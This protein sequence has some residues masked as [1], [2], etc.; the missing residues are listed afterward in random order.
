MLDCNFNTFIMALPDK[1]KDFSQE[2]VITFSLPIKPHEC[3]NCH[4]ETS[5]VHDYRR[6]KIKTSLTNLCN[7]IFI[8]RRRRYCCPHCK[9]VF[10]EQQTFI[11]KYQQIPYSDVQDI[12]KAHEEI[13]PTTK[14]ARRFCVSPTTVRRI[15]NMVNPSVRKLDKAVSLDEFHGNAGAKFQVVLNG[16]TQRKCL[17][18]FSNRS[19]ET[20]Y[21]EINQAYPIAER[22]KVEHVSIDLSPFFKRLVEDCFPNAQIAADHFHVVRMANEALESIRK[23]VQ[24]NLT[25]KQRKYFK[26][27]RWLLLKREK[28]LDTED[29]QAL[30]V[31]LNFSDK[32]SVAY[33]MKEQYFKLFDNKDMIEF[34]KKLLLFK[35]AVEKQNISVFNK[36]LKTTLKWKKEIIHG[37]TTGLNNGFTEGCNTVI[38]TLKRVSFGYR[39]FTVFRQR[40]I[41]V[42]NS[43]ARRCRRNTCHAKAVGA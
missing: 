27:S 26:R 14:I 12:I 5:R 3:P 36:L 34:N 29:Y 17:N 8:Y 7:M 31:L 4:H 13:E 6:Q 42:L 19:R 40:I 2:G 25:P 22:L 20:L 41:F 43:E 39:N 15:F 1:C 24:A 32:L 9:K 30:Q 35:M 38:K 23:E 37:I 16:L 21:Q 18:V 11:G 33:A 28:D 10:A